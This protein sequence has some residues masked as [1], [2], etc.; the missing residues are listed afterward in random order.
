MFGG[1]WGRGRIWALL[2][3]MGCRLVISA[4]FPS[5]KGVVCWGL[6]VT[7]G[8]SD[9]VWFY[10]DLVECDGGKDGLCHL[11]PCNVP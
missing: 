9:P 5:R 11:S 1:I 4:S 3:G 6:V 2:D 10:G 7:V 8:A